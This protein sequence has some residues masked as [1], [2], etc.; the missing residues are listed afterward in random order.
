MNVAVAARSE[1]SLASVKAELPATVTIQTNAREHDQVESAFT[2]A[3]K[4]FGQIDVAVV[5][6]SPST[7]GGA[8]GSGE[9]SDCSP[10]ALDPYARDLL[11]ALFTVLSVGGCFL[12]T[13]GSGTYIQLTG[14]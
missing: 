8:R 7:S 9:I 3:Q 2:D 10:S 11:P 13:Q 5:A 1:V 4:A 12:R 6:I 14:G